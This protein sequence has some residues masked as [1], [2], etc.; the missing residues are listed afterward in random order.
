MPRGRTWLA[1][2]CAVALLLAVPSTCPAAA[3]EPGELVL[4]FSLGPGWA[5]PPGDPSAH[6]GG[7]GTV[8]MG[9][10]LAP[11]LAVV[12]DARFWWHTEDTLRTELTLAGP[13]I[14]WQPWGPGPLLR[15]MVGAGYVHR[16]SELA[17][18][19]VDQRYDG[20]GGG[21]TIGWE[22]RP[23]RTVG[24]TP[25]LDAAWI[26]LDHGGSSRFTSATLALT[27]YVPP[28]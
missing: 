5:T 14:Q 16:I 2:A 26:R 8:V 13:G 18:T 21:V 3:G 15:A 9:W 27:W 19:S 6:A 23:R 12:V 24:V 17:A 25:E 1:A 28:R 22:W 20:A 4:G 11:S 7:A 10:S